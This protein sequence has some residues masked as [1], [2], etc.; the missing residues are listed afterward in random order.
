MVPY[1][2]RRKVNHIRVKK[3]QIQWNKKSIAVIIFSQY[4]IENRKKIRESL[5]SLEC[6]KLD[7]GGSGVF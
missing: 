2:A 4:K 5:K 6:S 3:V 7:T 1:I